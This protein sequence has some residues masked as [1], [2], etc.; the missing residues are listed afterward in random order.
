MQQKTDRV[1]AEYSVEKLLAVPNRLQR[2]NGLSWSSQ[3]WQPRRLDCDRLSNS[4]S[5][6]YEE[7][8]WQHTPL[9]ACNINGERSRFN[10]PDM[11]MNFW[12]GMQWL[13]G[14]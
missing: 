9:S 5:V 10:S 13:G 8:Q 14:Q 6:D 7:E 2:V 3:L 1:H 12:A 4:R 11:D